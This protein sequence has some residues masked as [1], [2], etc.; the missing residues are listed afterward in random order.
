MCVWNFLILE[1]SRFCFYL[2][3]KALSCLGFHKRCLMLSLS[4]DNLLICCLLS[5]QLT[6]STA[7][8]Y[9]A[10]TSFNRKRFSL[11]VWFWFTGCHMFRK[12][13]HISLRFL[14]NYGTRTCKFNLDIDLETREELEEPSLVSTV[15]PNS[16]RLW[17]LHAFVLSGVLGYG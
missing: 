13:R 3:F 10:Y 8:L 7:L 15:Y 6:S 12:N 11:Q 1:D 16:S 14:D 5:K 9:F 17:Y 4:N 2:A